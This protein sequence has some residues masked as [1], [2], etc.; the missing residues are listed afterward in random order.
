MRLRLV[1]LSTLN[2]VMAMSGVGSVL[3]QFVMWEGQFS[4]EA[5][6]PRQEFLSSIR[7]EGRDVAEHKKA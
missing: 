7:K 1:T 6:F 2:W 3:I 4:T 5:Q